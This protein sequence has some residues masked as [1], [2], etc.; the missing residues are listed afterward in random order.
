M[1]ARGRHVPAISTRRSP[2][3]RSNASSASMPFV[4]GKKAGAPEGSTVVFDLG[5]PAW[6]RTV[7]IG[8]EGGRAKL[9]DA[10]PAHQ[11][12]TLSTDTETFARLGVRAD[13]SDRPRSD[14]RRG[15]HR[16]RR[17]P[18]PACDRGD[19]LLVLNVPSPRPHFSVERST[20]NVAVRAFQRADAGRFGPFR[21]SEHELGH[22]L[23]RLGLAGADDHRGDARALPRLE[24][25]GDALP[26]P[27]E[28]RP[29]RR[30]RRAPPR[31]PRPSCRR[32]RGPGSPSPRPRSRSGTR[33]RCRSSSRE[34]PCRRRRARPSASRSRAARR[35]R[36]PRATVTVGAMSNS[37]RLLPPPA[38]AKPASS[39]SP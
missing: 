32:G 3:L 6:P 37:A 2:A 29:R 1:R 8:V 15:A 20:A 17:R 16:G 21:A 23:Q 39:A 9:L 14:D 7:A 30:A 35:G 11:T 12:V 31:S 34:R 25:V 13:R 19:E 24:P 28:R 5:A 26:R 27:E 18:R 33:G 22:E 36:R 4:V 10:A 38:F